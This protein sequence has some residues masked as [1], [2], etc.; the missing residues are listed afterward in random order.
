MEILWFYIAVILAISDEVHSKI[1]WSIF[2][3]FYI[4]LAEI[5]KI[6]LASNIRLWIVH[7][8]LEAIFHLIVL[9]IIFLNIEIGVL[10]ALIHMVVDIYHEL[11]GLQMTHLQHRALHFTVESI[12]F[13]LILAPWS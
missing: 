8:G 9:S 3:D 6:N 11:A 7:E 4:L 12:F 2:A 1:M 10:A 13:I 5:I